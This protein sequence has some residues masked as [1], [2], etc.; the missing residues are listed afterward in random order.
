MEKVAGKNWVGKLLGR[1]GWKKFGDV[2]VA[3]RCV[4]CFGGRE[5]ADR[6]CER[7]FAMMVCG[8]S[9]AGAEGERCLLS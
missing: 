1:I 3:A 5:F 4:R 8:L 9:L 7:C 2:G 6:N